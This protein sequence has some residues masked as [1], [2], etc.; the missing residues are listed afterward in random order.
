[1][2][3][4][5]QVQHLLSREYQKVY[6]Y[7]NHYTAKSTKANSIF[8]YLFQS[9]LL[10]NCSTTTSYCVNFN[11]YTASV[12]GRGRNERQVLNIS[13]CHCNLNDTKVI[14][15]FLLFSLL[16][17]MHQTVCCLKRAQI[18]HQLRCMT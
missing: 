7:Q 10:T 16:L 1:M 8:K 17:F 9:C 11:H 12:Q 3:N 14:F 5:Y 18:K 6:F 15:Q 2:F 13:A 4:I